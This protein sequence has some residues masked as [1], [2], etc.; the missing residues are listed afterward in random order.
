M[1]NSGLGYPLT[2]L[3]LINIEMENNY[4]IEM[5]S[6][7]EPYVLCPACFKGQVRFDFA[8]NGAKCDNCGEEFHREGMTLRYKAYQPPQCG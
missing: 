1:K 2:L 3:T 4:N 6:N 7:K 5:A 8:S